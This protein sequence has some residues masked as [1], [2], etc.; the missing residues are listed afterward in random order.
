ML[1]VRQLFV[2]L[3]RRSAFLP[4]RISGTCHGLS[5]LKIEIYQVYV[6]S[7]QK[8]PLRALSILSNYLRMGDLL[9]NASQSDYT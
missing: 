2:V 7:A 1:N 4:V 6:Q 5:M 8:N 3:V 9:L